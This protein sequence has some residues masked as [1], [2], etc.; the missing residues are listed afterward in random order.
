MR[1]TRKPT[2]PP[3]PRR[4]PRSSGLT[5]GRRRAE[6]GEKAKAKAK[7]KAEEEAM[8]VDLANTDD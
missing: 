8:V 1:R 7:G 5:I 3:G 6:T 4:S 2:S